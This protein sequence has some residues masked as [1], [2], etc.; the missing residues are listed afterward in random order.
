MTRTNFAAPA[1]VL[2]VGIAVLAIAIAARL[3]AFTD[4]PAVSAI[5]A[6][7]VQ[8]LA[9]AV[10]EILIG[11]ANTAT[12]SA[13][14]AAIAGLAVFPIRAT[15]PIVH[16][17]T[18]SLAVATAIAK[19][20]T[21]DTSSIVASLAR[22]TR[23]VAAAAMSFIATRVYAGAATEILSILAFAGALLARTPPITTFT[24][25][26][27]HTACFICGAALAGDAI[28]ASSARLIVAHT[29]SVPA[30]LTNC[31][32]RLAAVAAVSQAIPYIDALLAT[33]LLV[34]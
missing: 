22:F 4:I 9:V 21:A 16:A 31:A 12:I 5:V 19:T 34:S 3:A 30:Y 32:T 24:W 23:A 6:V 2:D 27:I 10:A 8:V 33:K 13:P 20:A 7:C 1:T 28:A 14:A 11:G 17:G 18:A 26:S 25:K 29:L 15:L